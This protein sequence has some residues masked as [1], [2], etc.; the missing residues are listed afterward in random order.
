MDQFISTMG[1]AGHALLIDCRDHST[2]DVKLDGPDLACVQGGETLV[3]AAQAVQG[4][5]RR[6]GRDTTRRVQAGSQ[7]HHLPD[8]VEYGDLA[9]APAG[10]DHMETVGTQIDG[11]DDRRVVLRRHRE[12]PPPAGGHL[13][14]R[15]TIRSRR[16]STRWDCGSRTGRR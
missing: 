11:G 7:S 16:S 13:R 5:G 8:P 4:P 10:D 12:A 9:I 2:R 6:L 15:R 1:K 14:R 3:E